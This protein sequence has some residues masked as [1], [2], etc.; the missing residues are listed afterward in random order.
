MSEFWKSQFSRLFS[1]MHAG[2]FKLVSTSHMCMLSIGPE[3]ASK[4]IVMSQIMSERSIF[5]QHRE[6]LKLEFTLG[7]CCQT[8]HIS[9]FTK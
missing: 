7:L 3:L 6:H 2:G 8:P 5:N 9:H 1:S 4:L